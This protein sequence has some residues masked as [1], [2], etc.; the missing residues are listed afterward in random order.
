MSDVI[1]PPCRCGLEFSPGTCPR[2]DRPEP[3]SAAGVRSLA[4]SL[5]LHRRDRRRR[6]ASARP[7]LEQLGD[8]GF[9]HAL[10]GEREE[11][12]ACFEEGFDRSRPE[13][14]PGD[15]FMAA[16]ARTGHL[17]RD[18]DEAVLEWLDEGLLRFAEWRPGRSAATPL[19]R[20]Q[21]Y[22]ALMAAR[23]GRAGEA[24][25]TARALLKAGVPED[26]RLRLAEALLWCGPVDRARLILDRLL[27]GRELD[28]NDRHIAYVLRI[29]CAEARGDRAEKSLW[30]RRERAWC[31]RH[32]RPPYGASDRPGT[33]SAVWV[34]DAARRAREPMDPALLRRVRLLRQGLDLAGSPAALRLKV[35]RD[36]PR[37]PVKA[38][39][40]LRDLD[41]EARRGTLEFIRIFQG[42][43]QVAPLLLA[44]GAIPEARQQLLGWLDDPILGP[45]AQRA[46]RDSGTVPA[47]E[48]KALQDPA[49]PGSARAAAALGSFSSRP[50]G[51]ALRRLVAVPG[52]E[53]PAAL[54]LA[55]RG[56]FGALNLVR[57]ALRRATPSDRPWLALAVARME[58]GRPH[59][60]DWRL[61]F[62]PDPGHSRHRVLSHPVEERLRGYAPV[63]LAEVKL[64][65]Q[66]DWE[67]WLYHARRAEPL[68]E[69]C[70]RR[71][72]RPRN[73]GSCLCS[74]PRVRRWLAL[75]LRRWA[76][77]GARSLEEVLDLL[78]EVDARQGPFT[79]GWD[80][81]V[82][83]RAPGGL[84]GPRTLGTGARWLLARGMTGLEEAVRNLKQPLAALD[85]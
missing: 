78:E 21:A 30:I 40:R 64:P 50:A 49:S 85:S 72:G 18:W 25:A 66:A 1:L 48:K 55:D 83:M 76:A 34:L 3:T 54:G 56:D 61:D 79:A 70:G 53:V 38:L 7:L 11:A 57:A 5:E 39:A 2:C 37:L 71:D 4:R 32:G 23:L 26:I 81:A 47:L 27:Q 84:N 16:V 43:L 82:R 31:R 8:L 6:Q 10:R 12:E 46:L 13:G 45:Y 62:R 42:R 17:C 73:S 63:E 28:E 65:P 24:R 75:E 51:A 22:R 9:E 74:L 14:Y 59:D 36:H 41:L 58:T 60:F 69:A 80:L 19:H 33:A 15:R 77:A 29:D 44:L 68:C 35:C 52:L 67:E 20:L